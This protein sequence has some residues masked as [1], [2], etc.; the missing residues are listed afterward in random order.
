VGLPTSS[1]SS[2]WGLGRHHVGSNFFWY[3][4]GLDC[5]VDSCDPVLL[6]APV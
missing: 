1:A 3:S 5:V 2:V 6:V 4:S